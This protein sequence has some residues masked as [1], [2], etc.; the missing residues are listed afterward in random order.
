[1]S[2]TPKR[3]VK[4]TVN[5]HAY[6]VEVDNL[7]ASPITV[8]VN[9]QPYQV[10]VETADVL[11]VSGDEPAA[12]LETVA[13]QGSAPEKAPRPIGPVGASVKEV[14]APMPGHIVDIVVKAGDQ[15]NRGQELCS[16]EAMKMKNA[17]RAHREGVI[18]RVDVAPGQAVGHGDVLM[19]FE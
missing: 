13:R 1:M 10:E 15:V 5:G 4:V 16:L 17:I 6:L 14:R 12:A 18:A 3:R 2:S 7:Y 11:P 8:R 19:T 9:G